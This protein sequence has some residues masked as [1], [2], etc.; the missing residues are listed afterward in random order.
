MNASRTTGKPSASEPPPGPGAAGGVPT[1]AERAVLLVER[2]AARDDQALGE[3]YDLFGATLYALALRIVRV[4]GDAEEITQ[5]AFL[6]AWERAATFDAH[7]AGVATWLGTLVRSRAI[8]RLR[9]QQSQAR[10]RAGLAL[11][12]A[13]AEG[14]P[15]QLPDDE[16][17]LN[18][19]GRQVR[20][21][22]DSL[23]AEQRE[24][25]EIAYFEGL[26]Q[27]EIAERLATPLGTVKTRMRQG[28]IKLKTML[29]AVVGLADLL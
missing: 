4:P 22:L 26:S 27:S 20:A 17:A 2:L 6:Y 10:R 11:Q 8:D 29:S 25:L 1:V 23:P 19:T 12:V 18:E 7:R 21:A 15:R 24:V 14:A 3:L 16:A 13:V 9:S 28:M 5:E